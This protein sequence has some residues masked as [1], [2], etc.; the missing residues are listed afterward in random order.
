MAQLLE[1]D[2]LLSSAICEAIAWERKEEVEIG[3]KE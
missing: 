1:W 3:V 2:E